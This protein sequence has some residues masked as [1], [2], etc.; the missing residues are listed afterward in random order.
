MKYQ[1]SKE[2]GQLLIKLCG[3]TRK[4]EAL[5]ARK[6]LSRYLT[7]QGTRV[8]VDMEELNQWEP[9]TLV[10]ILNGIRKEVRLLNGDLKLRSLKPDVRNYFRVHRLDRIFQFSKDEVEDTVERGENHGEE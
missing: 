2:K 1:I 5:S 3:N 4:N 9:W 7:S 10:G 6:R 8:I